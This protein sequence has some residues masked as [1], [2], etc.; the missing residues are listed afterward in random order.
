MNY[1]KNYLKVGAITYTP[2]L[3]LHRSVLMLT[4]EQKNEIANATNDS[5]LRLYEFYIDKKTWKHFNPLDYEKVGRELG[6]TA[7]K[8]EKCK[9]MLVKSGFLVIKKDT[10]KD[11]A[12]IYRI[13]L[14]KELVKKYNETNEF[15]D[16]N[17]T[18]KYITD[19]IEDIKEY[20]YI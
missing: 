9:I 6:W 13:L 7:S 12:K 3:K 4:L 10:L 18:I 11:G 16:D 15:P 17:E 1:S 19:S 8:T 5:A 14:G 2:K 20:I